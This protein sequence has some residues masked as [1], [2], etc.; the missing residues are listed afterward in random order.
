MK[1][2]LVAV[3]LEVLVAFLV[4]A[5]A[6]GVSEPATQRHG[7]HTNNWA[8]LVSSVSSVVRSVTV[9]RFPVS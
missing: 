7:S 4:A 5:A 9:S 1:M 3:S 6:V 8:V 2:A